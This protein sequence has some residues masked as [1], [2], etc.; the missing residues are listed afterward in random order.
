M[1]LKERFIA[2]CSVPLAQSFKQFRLGAVLF[3]IGLLVVYLA[4][5]LLAPSLQQELATLAGL[6][7]IAVGFAIAI[8]A[9]M[10]M[11]ASRLLAFWR[12]R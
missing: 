7:V 8:C 2:Y 3:F 10:R 9:Q 4:S 1:K 11:L 12:K 6:C 5:Q